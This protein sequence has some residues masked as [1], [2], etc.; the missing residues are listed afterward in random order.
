MR[1]SW[2]GKII[3]RV[4]TS[5]RKIWKTV[6]FCASIKSQVNVTEV[7]SVLTFVQTTDHYLSQKLQLSTLA[8]IAHFPK[9][10]TQ[11]ICV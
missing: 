5:L 1:Y 2:K 6:D 7:L 4:D 10:V 11:H 8:Y 9:N 3:P